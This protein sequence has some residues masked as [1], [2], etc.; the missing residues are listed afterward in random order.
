[1]FLIKLLNPAMLEWHRYTISNPI[2]K[3]K[4]K[5]C[6]LGCAYM[7]KPVEDYFFFGCVLLEQRSIRKTLITSIV[8]KNSSKKTAGFIASSQRLLLKTKTRIDK[9]YM[10]VITGGV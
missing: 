3:P 9:I 2:S 6:P 4:L 1:M 5:N 10:Q 7:F 8:E